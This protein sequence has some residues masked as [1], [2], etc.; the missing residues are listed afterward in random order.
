MTMKSGDPAQA[1]AIAAAI[2]ANN[3]R[4]GSGAS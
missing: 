2:A 3:K 4:P 1:A